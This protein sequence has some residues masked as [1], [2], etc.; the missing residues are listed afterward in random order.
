MR[1][2]YQG[3]VGK[4][5]ELFF[6]GVLKGRGVQGGGTVDNRNLREPWGRLG[7]IGESSDLPPWDP[8]PLRIPE[9]A[10]KSQYCG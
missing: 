1:G 6:Y 9:A 10:W 3:H 2:Q 8:L 4:P 7:S 5:L